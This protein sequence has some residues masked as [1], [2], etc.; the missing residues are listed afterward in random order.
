MKKQRKAENLKIKDH[1]SLNALS[2]SPVKQFEKREAQTC[3]GNPGDQISRRK[4]ENQSCLKW[5]LTTEERMLYNDMVKFNEQA[6]LTTVEKNHRRRL[7]S[8]VEDLAEEIRVNVIG[9][10]ILFFC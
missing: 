9:R 4:L 1:F 8:K 3:S 10:L 5:Q 7:R 6:G 2:K